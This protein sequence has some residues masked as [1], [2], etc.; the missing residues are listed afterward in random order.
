MCLIFISALGV[1]KIVVYVLHGRSAMSGEK[2]IVCELQ[3]SVWHGCVMAGAQSAQM[4]YVVVI[5]VIAL[6]AT[7]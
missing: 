3:V 4:K 6:A 2:D 5:V 7:S 1:C